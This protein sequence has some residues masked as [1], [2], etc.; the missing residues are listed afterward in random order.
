MYNVRMFYTD[1]SM[2]YVTNALLNQLMLSFLSSSCV[3]CL[4]AGSWHPL[5]PQLT[6]SRQNLFCL[7]ILKLSTTIYNALLSQLMLLSSC[8]FYLQACPWHTRYSRREAPS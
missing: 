2:P 3:F 1:T 7:K 8:Q 5:S 6:V 4:Q